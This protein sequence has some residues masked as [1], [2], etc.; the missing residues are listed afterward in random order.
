MYGGKEM[1]PSS[2]FSEGQPLTISEET[3][4][5]VALSEGK[6]N[7]ITFY[8]GKGMVERVEQLLKE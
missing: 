6:Y 3:L 7:L 5:K 4:Y 1:P 2:L 8:D